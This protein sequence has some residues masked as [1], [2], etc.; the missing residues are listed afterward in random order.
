MLISAS[1]MAV[2]A[3][4]LACVIPAHADAT[5]LLQEPYGNLGGLS[6]TGHAAIYFSRICA[7][8]PT[9]LRRCIPGETGVV[10]SRYRG[11]KKYD[12]IA[13]PLVPYLYAVDQLED[14]PESADEDTLKTLTEA[15]RQNHL[16]DLVPD[17]TDGKM[18]GGTWTEL[19]GAA[20]NRRIF[21][22]QLVTTEAQDDKL[23]EELN[24]QPNKSHFNFFFN[25][26]ADF[27]RRIL[28]SYFPK[29]VRRSF[30]GDLGL[31]TPK[32]VAKSLVKY[33]KKH[34]ETQLSVFVIPQVPGTLNRSNHIH[35][36]AE[37]LVKTKK[38]MLPL[39]FFQPFVMGGVAA[40][41]ITEGRF[42]PGHNAT[43]LASAGELSLITGIETENASNADRLPDTFLP[44]VTNRKP[45]T[46]TKLA[47]DPISPAKTH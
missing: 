18:P 32:Q 43:I 21:A 25:N 17:R 1:W 23:I 36:V 8:S 42:N 28:N 2:F 46:V 37:S 4:L 47:V 20:Y 33:H 13:T 10:I 12:W 5:F 3:L 9:V 30:I 15:Y 24:S 19:V 26:C 11:I 38:Y 39:V 35:G 29:A 31:M 22:F 41:Y 16:R 34:P 7:D 40:A 44:N 6:P 27:A 14:V 45:S